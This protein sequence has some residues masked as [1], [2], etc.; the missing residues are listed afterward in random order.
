MTVDD[1]GVRA[2]TDDGSGSARTTA[3]DR[4]DQLDGGRRPPSRWD[5]PAPTRDWRW[6]VGTIGKV[7]IA[8]GILM[9]GFVAY[10][11][12]G[13]GI[14]YAQAQDQLDAELEAVLDPA[15]ASTAPGPAS[16][17]A[18]GAPP[19]T[20]V[21][22]AAP[23]VTTVAG[24]LPPVAPGDALA[25]IEIPDIGVD[26]AVVEGVGREDL[27][28]GPG[29]YPSTPVPGQLGNAAI[30]GHRSTY[31]APFAE[32]DAMDI[33]DQIIVTTAQG[34]FVYRMTA[35]DIVSPSASQV[36]A[37]AD[38]AV[39]RLTLTTCHP[40]F[41][42]QQRLIVFADLD[43]ASSAI[44]APYAPSAAPPTDLAT[45]DPAAPVGDAGEPTAE[46]VAGAG[47]EAVDEDTADAFAQGWF[48][49]EGAFG[50][51]AMW[52][53]LLALIGV[54]AYALSWR[55]RSNLVGALAGIVPFVVVAYFF[56][57]NV[58]RLLPAAL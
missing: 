17:V 42:A 37:T 27:K 36:I 16:T 35:M 11:L 58:N 49:D 57:Q 25:R 56:F 24:A 44:P 2:A 50:Q 46:V 33:G 52:G 47:E 41:S 29:H 10:Q 12:W 4:L 20:T 23:A 51:V 5:R 7:L 13:T 15:T 22:P 21:T 34:R 43:I 28:R 3:L 40:E 6:A 55:T 38:P 32:L 30:A 26:A 48:S 18:P 1:R 53:S 14:E 8:T 39:A 31:G 45:E 9:F 19:A 54:G